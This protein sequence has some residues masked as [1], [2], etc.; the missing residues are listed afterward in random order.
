M[1]MVCTHSLMPVQGLASSLIYITGASQS[2]EVLEQVIGTLVNLA[3]DDASRPILVRG[4]AVPPL[5]SFCTS[6]AKGLGEYYKDR[7]TLY[8]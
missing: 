1:L 8:A 6:S 4:G 2:E 5:A 3:L 7:L